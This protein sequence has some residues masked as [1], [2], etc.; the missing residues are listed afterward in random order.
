MES[1]VGTVHDALRFPWVDRFRQA[2]SPASGRRKLIATGA[3]GSEGA[4][5]IHIWVSTS[6][7]RNRAA[8][9]TATRNVNIKVSTLGA[10]GDVPTQYIASTLLVLGQ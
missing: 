10:R 1:V 7:G 2:F 6:G 9:P 8:L 3:V 4:A 5:P